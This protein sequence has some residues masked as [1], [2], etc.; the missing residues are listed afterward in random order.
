M[1]IPDAYPVDKRSRRAERQIETHNQSPEVYHETA[2]YRGA[3]YRAT[4]APPQS[5]T[6][7]DHYVEIVET[8][9][10]SDQESIGDNDHYDRP[11]EVDT[12]T[13]TQGQ[14]CI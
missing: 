11:H 10:N 8:P 1:C 4:D 14:G 7:S 6:S 5:A 13:L 3:R 9:S 12:G 2:V